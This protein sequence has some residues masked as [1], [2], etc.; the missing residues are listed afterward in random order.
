MF[1]SDFVCPASWVEFPVDVASAGLS[2]HTHEGAFPPGLLGAG[3]GP[4][5]FGRKSAESRHQT[6]S[7]GPNLVRRNAGSWSAAKKGFHIS[8]SVSVVPG[9]TSALA[10]ASDLCVSLAHR[11]HARWVRFVTGHSR[12]GELPDDLD[13]ARIADSKTTTIFYMGG[14]TAAEIAAKLAAAGM[15][16]ATPV[17][18]SKSVS[19]QG[20]VRWFWPLHAIPEGIAITGYEEPVLIG[21]GSVLAG[22]TSKQF[23]RAPRAVSVGRQ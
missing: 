8:V 13:W 1:A 19:R 11:D 15:D 12:H 9:I 7:D 18:V 5:A 17:V 20:F 14:R 2:L 21:I 22:V 3:C 23:E 10:I 4:A 6:I 16:Q